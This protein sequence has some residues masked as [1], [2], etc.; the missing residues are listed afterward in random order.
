M[1]IDMFDC[2]WLYM[3]VHVHMCK[4]VCGGLRLTLGVFFFNC[5]LPY[6]LRLGLSVEPR[7]ANVGKSRC[8]TC[9]GDSLFLHFEG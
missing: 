4:C 2:L 8:Q 9:H 5:P 6:S 1:H 3:C 7:I